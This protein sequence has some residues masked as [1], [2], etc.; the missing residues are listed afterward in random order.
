MALFK[1]ERFHGA[2]EAFFKH[3]FELTHHAEAFSI[4]GYRTSLGRVSCCPAALPKLPDDTRRFG[5]V[6]VLDVR[7]G[8]DILPEYLGPE[9]VLMTDEA[10]KRLK[11]EIESLKSG[12]ELSSLSPDRDWRSHQSDRRAHQ[13]IRR[14]EKKLAAS[15]PL[16]VSFLRPVAVIAVAVT[17]LLIANS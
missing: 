16:W 9:I 7:G 10:R 3:S 14:V 17:L 6:S 8:G 4:A 5:A 13:E 12:M 15:M 2:Q 11:A 1:A